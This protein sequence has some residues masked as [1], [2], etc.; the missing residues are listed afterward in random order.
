MK[1]LI[2]NYLKKCGYYQFE[3]YWG[4][5]GYYILAKSKSCT[6]CINVYKITDEILKNE[7]TDGSSYDKINI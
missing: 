6:Q 4:R 1:K 3:W 5:E 7:L 2:E